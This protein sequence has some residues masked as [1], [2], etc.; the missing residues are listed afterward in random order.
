MRTRI[1]PHIFE[2]ITGI[3]VEILFAI[4]VMLSAF[5]IGWVIL[6]IK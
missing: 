3:F 2:A 4:L 6:L 1:F 5:I